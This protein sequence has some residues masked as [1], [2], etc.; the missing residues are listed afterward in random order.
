MIF[1]SQRPKSLSRLNPDMTFSFISGQGTDG[2]E[3]SSTMWQRV[4]G[5]AENAVRSYPFKAAYCFRPGYIHPM[6][7]VKSRTRVYQLL[8]PIFKPLYPL[9]KRMTPTSVTTSVNIGRAM[10]NSATI[11]YEKPILENLDINALAERA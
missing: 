6:K 10:I 1:Q 7:G 11:G 2:T 5:K 9:L 3:K 8:I 4:K